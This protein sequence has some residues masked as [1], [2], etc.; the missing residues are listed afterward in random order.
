MFRGSSLY[1]GMGKLS[2][3]CEARLDIPNFNGVID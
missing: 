3:V 2:G 1:G